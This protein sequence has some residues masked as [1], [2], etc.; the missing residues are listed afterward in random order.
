MQRKNIM[1]KMKKI[2]VFQSLATALSHHLFT[3]LLGSDSSI[4][5]HDGQ[6][7]DEVICSEMLEYFGEKPI[8]K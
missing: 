1:F 6:H 2:S 7:D 5:E 3:G 4:S 8:N